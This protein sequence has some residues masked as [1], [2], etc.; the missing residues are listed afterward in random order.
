MVWGPQGFIL[1]NAD[2]FCSKGRSER[3]PMLVD[4]KFCVYTNRSGGNGM[5]LESNRAC[6]GMHLFIK[7]RS[8]L[9]VLYVCD[10]HI[11]VFVYL[12]GVP[13]TLEIQIKILKF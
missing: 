5:K 10:Y 13:R 3:P 6:G 2:V 7:T 1:F 8:C 4:E 9:Y 12:G 11:C